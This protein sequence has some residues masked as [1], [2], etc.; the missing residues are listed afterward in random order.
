ML[1]KNI[2]KAKIKLYI[3]SGNQILP[4]ITLEVVQSSWKINSQI[5]GINLKETNFL[6]FFNF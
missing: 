1:L 3:L 2:G 5:L 4:Y 6:D